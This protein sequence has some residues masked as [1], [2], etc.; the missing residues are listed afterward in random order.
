MLIAW[1]VLVPLPSVSEP[2]ISPGDTAVRH[3]LQLLSDSQLLSGPSMSWPIPWSRIHTELSALEVDRLPDPIRASAR[4]LRARASRELAMGRQPG[5]QS[6]RMVG[7]KCRENEL[8]PAIAERIAGD[9][10]GFF[11]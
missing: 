5:M 9:H 11:G 6:W 10:A 1:L 4:R 3:D 2:W 8:P 7:T